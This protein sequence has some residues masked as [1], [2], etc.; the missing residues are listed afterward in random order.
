MESVFVVPALVSPKVPANLVP[1]ICKL[2]ERNIILTY[3]SQLRI[4]AMKRFANILK[5]ATSEDGK[6]DIKKYKNLLKENEI[7]YTTL[8]EA[9]KPSPPGTG[10]T[11]SGKNAPPRVIPLM[12]NSDAVGDLGLATSAGRAVDDYSSQPAKLKGDDMEVPKGISFYTTISLEPTFLEIPIE[13]KRDIFGITG[14]SMRIIRIG[15]KCIPYNLVGV[16]NVQKALTD[17]KN[18]AKI[19]GYWKSRWN[20]I[21]KR[22][23]MSNERKVYK[24]TMST[25]DQ[26]RDV[27]M[28]PSSYELSNPNIL[29]SLM[30]PRAPSRWTTMVLFSSNDFENNELVDSMNDYRSMVNAGWGDMV[31]VNSEK[32]SIYF[33]MQKLMACQEIPFSYLRKIMSMDDVFDYKEVS[34]WTRPFNF[35]SI[36]AAMFEGDDP[37]LYDVDRNSLIAEIEN[38]IL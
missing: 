33:C 21:K 5:T 18:Q 13:M 29:A 38:T 1:L 12:R 25:G 19:Q 4:A 31:V 10:G 11:G 17:T 24:G 20:S 2:V 7:Y 3:S 35:K 36:R 6:I 37:A 28:G 30:D 9:G 34:K 23:W 14:S 22:V 32:E 27:V 16:E 15:V 8:D 26:M